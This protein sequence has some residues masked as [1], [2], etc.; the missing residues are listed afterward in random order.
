MKDHSSIL[1]L[2]SLL[3]LLSCQ[4]DKIPPT[5]RAEAF[6]RV[7]DSLNYIELNGSNSI[8]NDT[9]NEGLLFSW[10]FESDGVWESEDQRE[11]VCLTILKL[12][13]I[14][15]VCLRV[16][17]HS[18]LVDYD[19]IEVVIY[20][21]NYHFGELTDERDG[22]NYKT[23][24]LNGSWWMAENLD[25]GKW[26]DSQIEPE[27]N[28][29]V[30]KY[31][32]KD[33]SSQYSSFG[34]LYTW[35]EAKNYSTIEKGICPDGWHLPS[36]AEWE[37]LMSN[38]DPWFAW[39]YYGNEG[40]SGFNLHNGKYARREYSR[41][42][43]KDSIANYWTRDKGTLQYIS[44]SV[45][46]VFSYSKTWGDIGIRLIDVLYDGSDHLYLESSNYASVRC[47]KNN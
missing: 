29:I 17:D 25:Y 39:Q 27:D 3:V 35:M 10:D 40:F 42:I 43:W 34:S 23:I 14:Y 6:P 26:I 31:Y 19:T 7:S 13:C 44:V 18:G 22:H 1:L 36:S 8:D 28:G 32:F 2:V 9:Y 15:N 38:M 5:A 37:F 33:D 24:L 30:E 41:I 45:P 20:G 4:K 21:T 12:P 11:P 16:K 47:I 46:K